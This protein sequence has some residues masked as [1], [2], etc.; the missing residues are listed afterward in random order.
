MKRVLVI[1]CSGAGKSTFAKRLH[2]IVG[3]PLIHLDLIWHRAD[4]T[5]I[6]REEFDA[7][8]SEILKGDEWIIDGDYGR[9]LETRLARCDCVYFLDYPLEVCLSGVEAR[10]GQPRSDMPWVEQDF[11]ADFRQWILQ[12]PEKKRPRILELLEQYGE[13]KEIFVFHTREESDAYLKTL[14]N[15]VRHG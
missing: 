11:D 8:L 7:R 1:G 9:T 2:G 5:V 10:I 14:E 6:S 12:F 15:R 3:L 4:R 13:G